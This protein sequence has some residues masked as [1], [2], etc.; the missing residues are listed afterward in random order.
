MKNKKILI[1]IALLFFILFQ[2]CENL[3]QTSIEVEKQTPY[4]KSENISPLQF[5]TTM[6]QNNNGV[7]QLNI[8]LSLIEILSS[9]DTKKIEQF[10]YEIFNANVPSLN[11]SGNIENITSTPIPNNSIQHDGK[12]SIEIKE[13]DI[14]N[15]LLQVYGTNSETNNSN[16]IITNFIVLRENDPPVIEQVIAPDTLIVDMPTVPFVISVKVSDPQGLSDINRVYFNSYRPDGVPASG[17][18]F[19]MFDDGDRYGPS[20]DLVANDGIFSLSI[21]ITQE[22]LKGTYRFDFYVTDRSN[23]TSEVYQHFIVVK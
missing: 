2:S 19:N 5:N 14:G 18:P 21:T 15:Y 4:I 10:K 22:N 13:S 6:L 7:V 8:D 11:F 1:L 16:S 17:N 23:A 9:N 20:G 12:I 3:N